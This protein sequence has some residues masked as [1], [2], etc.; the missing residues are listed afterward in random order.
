MKPVRVL[1]VGSGFSAGLHIEGYQRSGGAA[2]IVGVCDSSQSRADSFIAKHRLEGC[3]AFIDYEE[4]IASAE[5]DVVDICAPNFLHHPIAIAALSRGR[6]VICEKALATTA[7]EGREM[8]E[9]ARRM[10]RHIYYAEDWHFAPAIL[11]AREIIEEGGIG[12]VHY[13]RARECHSGSHSPYAQKIAMCGG[14]AMMNLGVHPLGLML[15]MHNNEWTELTAVGSG[16]GELNKVHKSLEGEDWSACFLHFADGSTALIEANYFTTG[17]MED[18]VDFYGDKGCLH[19]N[20][21]HE[22]SISCYSIPGL[23]YTVE[24]AEVTTGWSH[25]AFDEMYTLGYIDEILHFIACAAED[26][27]A[28]IGLRGEDGL[29]ALEVVAAC[30]ASMKEKRSV[31]NPKRAA[32]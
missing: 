26:K 23:A 12:R 25:P 30:Y 22:G 15:A 32:P 19:I 3:Q 16:G 5:C 17:G 14:G 21:N 27:E 8:V 4:A 6:H 29:A 13:M 24:K 20:L 1:I 18:I 31:Q 11:R 28:R 10:G 7:E 2:R 9:L